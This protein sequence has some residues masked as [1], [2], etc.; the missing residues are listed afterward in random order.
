MPIQVDYYDKVVYITSPTTTVTV[1]ELVDAIRAAEDTPEGM[2][3]G[4]SVATLV[5]AVTDAEGKASVGGG[6]LAGIVM[7]L[8]SDWYIEFWDGVVLGT[9]SGGN[10]TGGLANRPVRCAVG[11]SDT[12]L[13][14]GAV[15]G[16]IAETGTSGLT[17]E[18]STELF[19]I[20]S[21][22]KGADDDDLKDISDQLDVVQADL[23]NPN[24]YKADVSGLPTASEVGDEVWDRDLTTHSTKGSAGAAQQC[25]LYGG[26]ISIDIANGEAGSAW[27]IGTQ[28]YP[29]NNLADALAIAVARKID[30]FLVHG[31]IT[32]GATD[33]IDG[34]TFLGHEGWGPKIVFTAGCSANETAYKYM[35]LE[36]ELSPGDTLLVESCTIA[37]G[38]L[39]NFN[40]V[41][42]LVNLAQGTEIS[43]DVWANII[44]GSAGGEPTNEPE[45]MLNSS[46]VTVT[47]YTGNLK[48]KGKT[49][50][51]RTTIEGA[52]I[53]LI[54]DSTCTGGTIQLLGHGHLE[55]DN[56]GP[57]CT[58][59][60]D[61]F[62][63]MATIDTAI[64]TAETNVRGADSD[65]LKTLS[66][67]LDVAQAD[68]DDPDQYKADL[69]SVALE[70]TLQ[71]VKTETDK[72]PSLES[73]LAFIG[74][75]EGGRWKIENN[76]MIF[77][78][79]DNVTEVARFNLFDADGLPA[80]TDVFERVRV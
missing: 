52:G 77:Y 46:A 14:L 4:G 16:V 29:V 18:E 59:D 45:L 33:V 49:G 40:G 62:L 13:Q 1:Q 5:D 21:S 38:G 65:D 8:K 43:V 73:L 79:D 66:D 2:A 7:T 35:E 71:L 48:V 19:S 75:I 58:V 32:I 64:T 55:A 67:Q 80:E 11:S 56:S 20:K 26:E 31:T 9:V 15:G 30:T 36:G 37:S 39:I 54:I 63:S 50:A 41:M 69:T 76:Q 12:A 47:K 74:S 78:E 23:D 17:S 10:V 68:L 42:N 51:N 57:G 60:T 53:N 61:G 6:F 34:Y 24:Q 70:A 72:I 22:I 44:E 25:Q 28:R 27:P 3:F